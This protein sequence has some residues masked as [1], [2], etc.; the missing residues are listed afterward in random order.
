LDVYLEESHAPKYLIKCARP[1]DS[2]EQMLV[3]GIADGSN[4]FFEE[5]GRAIVNQGGQLRP[6]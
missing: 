1:K 2:D 3:D 4:F 6:K 5:K